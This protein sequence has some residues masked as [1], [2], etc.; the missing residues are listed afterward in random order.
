[1]LCFAPP[2][3]RRAIKADEN[4]D[5]R[6]ESWIV[7]PRTDPRAVNHPRTDLRSDPRCDPRLGDF[8]RLSDNALPPPYAERDR[9]DPHAGGPGGAAQERGISTVWGDGSGGSAGERPF[10]DDPRSGLDRRESW[11]ARDGRYMHDIR[12]GRDP[13]DL[14]DARD[15]RDLRDPRDLHDGRTPRDLRDAHALYE[16]RDDRDRRDHRDLHET[17]TLRDGHDPRVLYDA[18]DGIDPRDPRALWDGRDPRDMPLGLDARELRD[19]PRE[20]FR[21]A[22]LPPPP[23]RGDPRA[24]HDDVDSRRAGDGDARDAAPQPP[25]PPPPPPLPPSSVSRDLERGPK[26]KQNLIYKQK[27][28]LCAHDDPALARYPSSAPTPSSYEGKYKVLSPAH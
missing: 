14:Y 26:H 5:T 9:F 19:D 20:N 4:S 8:D 15:G 13:R 3:T 23:H 24:Y 10:R 2:Q 11:D 27:Q 12:D 18:R 1:M 22:F 21:D 17:R 28:K 6:L 7:D 16:A 25:P